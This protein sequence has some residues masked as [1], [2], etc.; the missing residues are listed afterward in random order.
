M[1]KTGTK[2]RTDFEIKAKSFA[3]GELIKEE[4]KLANDTRTTC[5]IKLEQKKALFQALKMDIAI[6]NFRHF[7]NLS[8]LDLD[9]KLTL[10]FNKL[11]A[12]KLSA[13]VLV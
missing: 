3:I 10:Q 1:A 9:E 12:L 2:E 5:R 13:K 11:S 8:N 6:F 7:I 4:R